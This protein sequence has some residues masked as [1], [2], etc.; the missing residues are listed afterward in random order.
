MIS[1]KQF[2]DRAVRELREVGKQ[3][4]ALATDRDLYQKLESEVIQPNP[5]LSSEAGAYLAMVRGA[6]TDATS[7][8]LRRIFNLDSAL[9]IR[10]LMS[11]LFDHPDLLHG[12]LT[13]TELAKDVDAVNQ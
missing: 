13:A 3:A 11:Q 5:R 12:K 1:E 6:Y 2:K 7:M 10:R 9:S 8:R 4:Q